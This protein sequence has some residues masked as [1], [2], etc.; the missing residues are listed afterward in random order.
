MCLKGK[1]KG[2]GIYLQQGV[3]KPYNNPSSG[4]LLVFFL[5]ASGTIIN[6]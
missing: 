2:K 6:N 1:E 3:Y 5:R 4:S